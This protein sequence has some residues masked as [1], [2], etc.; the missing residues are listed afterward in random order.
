MAVNRNFIV[1]QGVQVGANLTIGGTLTSN[2]FISNKNDVLIRPSLMLDFSTG[3]LDSRVQSLRNS[4]ASYVAANRKIVEVGPNTPRVE[5]D[6]SGRCLGLLS[7]ETRT[8]L[9][10]FSDIEGAVGTVPRGM[11]SAG[12]WP[13]QGPTVSTDVWI[14]PNRQSARHVRGLTGGGDSNVGYLG[15][16][17]GVTNAWF[18]GSVYVYI[19]STTNIALC[20]LT[21]ESGTLVLNPNPGMTANLSLRD[22]WQRLTATSLVTGGTGTAAAVLRIEPVGAFVYSDCWQ[23]ER[24]EY[25]SSW[26]PT[27]NVGSATRQE[28]I[29]VI[30]PVSP[31][32]NTASF[33]VAVE[34]TPRWS[35]NALMTTTLTS[36]GSA[37][38][39]R[40]LWALDWSV[41]PITQFGATP[42][43]GYSGMIFQG[44]STGSLLLNS[45]E[46][47]NTTHGFA[48]SG[49]S[50]SV[51][52][53]SA[54]YSYTSNVI[55]KA[56][57]SVTTTDTKLI[58]NGNNQFSTYT[59]SAYSNNIFVDRLQIGRQVAG[60]VGPLTFGGYI[61]KISLYSRSLSNNELIALTEI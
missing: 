21:L 49:T 2:T 16:F 26:I 18:T 53:P 19:P 47:G 17:T 42:Y 37:N 36:D 10:G 9:S 33:G 59:G 44:S 29:N 3:Q 38:P 28:D 57:Y 45:R 27:T 4:N 1:K 54:G 6:L 43:N 56:A 8:N 12:I 35:A 55:F 13:D 7:E 30:T 58:L 31:Y 25:A 32:I 60:G 40:G 20:I 52:I 61:K 50:R 46:Y 11:F 39:N 51:S 23:V 15:S 24:G 41:G 48:N 14:G 22:T 5:W 34:A